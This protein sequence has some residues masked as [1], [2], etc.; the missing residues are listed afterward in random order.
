MHVE[1]LQKAKKF[2]V[3]YPLRTLLLL[4]CLWRPILLNPWVTTV[5]PKH[6]TCRRWIEANC[7]YEF[8]LPI[9]GED[10]CIFEVLAIVEP[11]C[12]SFRILVSK[13][14]QTV[15]SLL[16]ACSSSCLINSNCLCSVKGSCS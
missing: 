10:Q 1:P 15:Y 14:E 11:Y 8:F 13:V 16:E 2:V 7:S 6:P 3:P 4:C 5:Y 9:V 12:L